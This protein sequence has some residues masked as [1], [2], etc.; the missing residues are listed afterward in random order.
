[1][2]WPGQ[3]FHTRNKKQSFREILFGGYFQERKYQT[4]PIVM[5]LLLVVVAILAAFLPAFAA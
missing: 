4:F 3:Q 1:M 5:G 2:I